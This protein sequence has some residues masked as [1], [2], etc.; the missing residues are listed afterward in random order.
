MD[1]RQQY[2]PRLFRD[3]HRPLMIVVALMAALAAVA[4]IAL[5][6]DNRILMGAPIWEKPLKFALSFIVYG[7]VLAL[8]IPMLDKGERLAHWCGNVIAA[9]WVIE[10]VIIVGQVVRG[11]PSHFNAE[12][13]LDA[14]LFATMGVVITFLWFANLAIAVLLWRHTFAD[15]AVG[16]SIRLGVA[17]SL[18]GAAVGGAMV[19]P[20]E[21]LAEDMIG[22]HTVGS[23]DGGPSLPFLGW[24]SVG[25]DLR[26]GHFV[27][28]HALQVLPLL[29]I[30]LSFLGRSVPWLSNT[31]VRARL[32]VVLSAGYLGLTALVTWQA[33][34][35]EPLH[36]PSTVITAA[37]VALVAVVVAASLAVIRRGADEPGDIRP[38]R[39]SEVVSAGDR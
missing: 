20:R 36:R 18:L 31:Q 35:A 17:I 34:R 22:A 27:G 23:A 10:M 12:T 29:G 4:L 5:F 8:L 6:F 24:S 28:M 13:T 30:A 26:I 14:V 37:G 3:A 32:I 11:R 25:G 7:A 38:Y 21:N 15:K 2:Y 19:G 33:F 39:E 1:N 16:W 9:A